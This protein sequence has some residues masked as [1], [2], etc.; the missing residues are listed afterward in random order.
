MAEP[1][2]G[3]ALACAR[4]AHLVGAGGSGM[5]TLAHLLLDCG[6][7]VSGS[8]LTDGPSLRA[9][10]ARGA[11]VAVGH[12]AANLA[13]PRDK[14]GAAGP[15]RPDVVI[16]S[17]AVGL[18]NPELVEATRL[19]CP[20][21]SHAQ[22][23]GALMAER[24]GVAVAGTHGK[25][26]TTAL[27]G[28]VLAH[29]GLDPT[30]LVGA[31]V[32]QFGSGARAGRGP[33]LVVEADEYDHRFLEL[34]PHLAIITSLEADHLDYF[35]GLGAIVEA[36]HAF[37]ERVGPDG[38]LVTCSDDPLLRE[39]RF[40]RR[41]LS[42]GFGEG[43]D[44][45]G[46]NYRPVAGGGCAFD[47]DS[48][49]GRLAVRLRLSGRHNVLNTLAAL[50]AAAELGV[51][52][53]VAAE[54]VGAFEGTQRRFQTIARTDNLWIVDDYAHHPSAV[55]AT[56]AAAREAHPG[57]LW[58]VLEPHTAHRTRAFLGEF[59]AALSQADRVTVLPIFHP[60]GREPEAIPVRSADLAAL[61]RDRPADAPP[62]AD[63]AIAS[64]LDELRPGDLVLVMGAGD[65][66]AFA[67][68]LAE[69]LEVEAR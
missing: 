57:R 34:R 22:A 65:S 37:A 20:V 18:D 32:P 6:V 42:Y 63:A 25:S 59:A 61:V 21:L 55:A 46:A 69:R 47:V 13:L 16:R 1:V 49:R 66:S 29:T 68:A 3:A 4:W 39:L 53:G 5:S 14:E 54:A 38:L 27:V 50:A 52:P 67:R 10:A 40:E 23:I 44:W 43:A 58:A 51:E 12:R 45:R 7:A 60:P 56:L 35:G 30:V 9:L 11:A 15:A 24:I 62:S 26:T 33:H 17:A 2:Q 8:D 64:V 19:G 31:G 48:P 41:R 36:F 28:F